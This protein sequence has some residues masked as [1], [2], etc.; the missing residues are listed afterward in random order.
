MKAGGRDDGNRRAWSKRYAAPSVETA[1]EKRQ[2]RQQDCPLEDRSARTRGQ[3][4]GIP[5]RVTVFSRLGA[6]A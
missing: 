6:A 5:R 2:S 4:P 1:P 3:R